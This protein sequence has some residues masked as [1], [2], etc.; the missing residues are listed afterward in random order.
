[1]IIKSSFKDYYDHIAHVYGG[2]DPKNI[3]MR[4]RIKERNKQYS[5][6]DIGLFLPDIKLKNI[7]DIRESK[8]VLDYRFKRLIICGKIYLLVKKL[9]FGCCTED[10]KLFTKEDFPDLYK[11]L[12]RKTWFNGEIKY[13]D[14]CGK[15]SQEFVDLSK[16]LNTPVFCIRSRDTYDPAGRKVGI[17]IDGD[18]PILADLG[19]ASIIKPHQM[20]QEISYFLANTMNGS[21]DIQPIGK[22][23]ITDKEK[24]LSHGFDLKQS[25]RHRK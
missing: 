2:G 7:E 17:V 1:M 18:I 22:P 9:I 3:Y 13:E 23:P 10:F 21:P 6:I 4:H 20:Y 25:F 5:G 8:I 12:I 11:V 15:F 14:Y 19:F 24:T 16:K